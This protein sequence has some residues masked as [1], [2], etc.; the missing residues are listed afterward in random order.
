MAGETD[1][2][3]RGKYFQKHS[4]IYWLGCSTCHPST[5]FKKYDYHYGRV[6]KWLRVPNRDSRSPHERH[7]R[8]SITNVGMVSYLENNVKFAQEDKND[9]ISPPLWQ[10]LIHLHTCQFILHVYIKVDS[11]MLP[12]K[13]PCTPRDNTSRQKDAEDPK[14]SIERARPNGPSSKIGLLPTRSDNHPH[15]K[16]VTASAK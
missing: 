2:L 6:F 9:I 3:W 7:H 15:W 14:L 8:K 4:A 16:T 10:F 11:P 12:L 5:D 13:M 1:A